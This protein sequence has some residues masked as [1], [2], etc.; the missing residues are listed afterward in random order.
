MLPHLFDV[1]VAVLHHQV[2]GV[3]L[4]LGL[5]EVLLHSHHSQAEDFLEVEI[6]FKVDSKFEFQYERM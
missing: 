5:L 6:C 4:P 1:G 2:L 3:Q